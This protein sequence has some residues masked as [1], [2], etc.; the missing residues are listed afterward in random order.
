LKAGRNSDA[1]ETHPKIIPTGHIVLQNNLPLKK[2]AK[3]INIRIRIG[4]KTT[5]PDE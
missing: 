2:A 3:N 4:G 5:L 1:C